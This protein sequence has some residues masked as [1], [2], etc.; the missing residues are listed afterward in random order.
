MQHGE[1]PGD[2]KEKLEIPSTELNRAILEMK[3]KHYADWADHPLDPLGG[4][5]PREASRT[6]AG[7]EQV[8][9][10]LKDCENHEAREPEGQ[11][12]DFSVLRR[13]LEVDT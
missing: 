12:F 2:A 3:K 10:L 5:T 6:R 9:L 11:R 4:M 13:E 8:D 7:R 1:E